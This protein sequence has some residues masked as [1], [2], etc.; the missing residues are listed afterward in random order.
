[1]Y[2][3]EKAS[4]SETFLHIA[5]TCTYFEGRI[6]VS[7]R[8]DG[9]SVRRIFTSKTID[10]FLDNGGGVIYNVGIKVSAH[11]DDIGNHKFMREVA[12]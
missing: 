1:M 8:M 12:I 6:S 4:V 5:G 10:V 9:K 11:R 2:G 7:A 3:N